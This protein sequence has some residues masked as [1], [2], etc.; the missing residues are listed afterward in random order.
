MNVKVILVL[1]LMCCPV[2]L[3]VAFWQLEIIYIVVSNPLGWGFNFAGFGD[4]GFPEWLWRDI[5]YAI[6]TLAYM[7]STIAAFLLGRELESNP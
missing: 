5:G 6:I 7:V 4:F 2:A 3:T 1:I